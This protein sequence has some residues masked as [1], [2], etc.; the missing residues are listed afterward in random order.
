MKTKRL[1]SALL[2]LALVF[3]MIQPLISAFAYGESTDFVIEN[4]ILTKYTGTDSNVTVPDSVT[5]IGE[6]AFNGNTHIN[7]V[8]IPESVTEI[9]NVSFANCTNLS[10]VTFADKHNSSAALVIGEWVFDKCPITG[11]TFPTQLTQLKAGSLGSVSSLISISIKSA[12]ANIDANALSTIADG[13]RLPVLVPIG[14]S[15]EAS[16]RVATGYGNKFIARDITYG[17][18]DPDFV[19]DGNRKLVAYTGEGG[20]VIIPKDVTAIRN[21]N[22]V[23]NGRTDIKS[24]VIPAAVT[25]IEDCCFADCTNLSL[26]AFDDNTDSNANLTIKSFVF[27]NC[28]ITTLTLPTQLTSL[29]NNAFVN[30][31]SLKYITVKSVKTNL[32][33]ADALNNFA[34]SSYLPIRVDL[35]SDTYKNIKAANGYNNKFVCR[36]INIQVNDDYADYIVNDSRELIG[37]TGT[38]NDANVV[39]P[40]DVK[41]IVGSA[42]VFQGKT[43]IK[44]IT[45]N[46]GVTAILDGAFKDCSALS[47]LIIQDNNE[48]DANLSIGLNVF[49]GSNLTNVTLPLQYK[50]LDGNIFKDNNNIK[51]ITIKNNNISLATS[52]TLKLFTSANSYFPIRIDM[53]NGTVKN[54]I[55]N[56]DGYEEHYFV[57]RDINGGEATD[58][59]GDFVVDENGNFLEYKGNGGN[60]TIP[61]DVNVIPNGNNYFNG[62]T[63]LIS[64]YV[65]KNVTEIEDCAFQNCPKLSSVVFEDNNTENASL[66]MG[67]W[68]FAGDAITDITLPTHLTYIAN[69]AFG[70][71]SKLKYLVIKAKNLEFQ[72]ENAFTNFSEQS[73]FPIIV[74]FNNIGL[75]N[76]IKGLN[77]YASGSETDTNRFFCRDISKLTDNFGDFEVK[78]INGELTLIKYT[79]TSENVVIPGD[80]AVI[81]NSGD[82]FNGNQSIKSITIPGSVKIIENCAISNCNNLN[83]V[84]FEDN[85]DESAALSIGTWVFGGDPI[86]GIT[87]PTQLTYLGTGA[88]GGMD[89]LKY[90]V[91]KSRTLEFQDENA[92]SSFSDQSFFPI[93]VDLKN[94]ALCD[95]IKGLTDYATE[96]V[97]EESDG[98]KVLKPVNP[99]SHN[100]FMCRDINC[101]PSDDYGNFN[102][103]IID[104][105]LTLVEYKGTAENVVIPGDVEVLQD[106]VFFHSESARTHMKT[107]TVPYSVT[108]IQPSIVAGCLNLTKI[109]FT[110]APDPSKHSL[111]VDSFAF[112]GSG[113]EELWLPNHLTKLNAGCFGGIDNLKGVIITANNV[114]YDENAFQFRSYLPVFFPKTILQSNSFTGFLKT[115]GYGANA[116]FKL[117]NDNGEDKYSSIE[118]NPEFIVDG[119][120]VLL[121]Y[122]P[123]KDSNGNV[124]SPTEIV[125]PEDVRVLGNESCSNLSELKKLVI[126][127]TVEEIEPSALNLCE[128][129]VDI[130]FQNAPDPTQ[131][132]LTIDGFAFLNTAVEELWLPTHLTKLN[133]GCFGGTSNLKGVIITAENVE[134]DSNA[135]QFCS[136][137]TVFFPRENSS[138]ASF[139][140]LF[141]TYEYGKRAIFR[142]LDDNGNTDYTKADDDF[143]IDGEGTLTEYKGKGGIVCVPEGVVTLSEGVF[144]KAGYTDSS[145][146]FVSTA[147]DITEI[148]LP[149]TLRKIENVAF[150]GCKNLVHVNFAEG[151]EIINQW[152]FNDTGIK[153]LVLPASIKYLDAGSLCG[154]SDDADFILINSNDCKINSQA[155]EAYGWGRLMPVLVNRGSHTAEV[156]PTLGGYGKEGN[157]R[158]FMRYIDQGIPDKTYVVDYKD[159]LMKYCGN[160]GNIRIPSG[161]KRIA[162]QVFANM[163]SITSVTFPSSLKRIDNV[164]FAGCK[165]LANVTFSEGFE[166]LGEWVF[167]NTALTSII[168]PTTLKELSSGSCSGMENIK[169]IAILAQDVNINHSAFGGYEWDFNLPVIVPEGSKCA[170]ILPTLE[171]YGK[172]G[173][174]RFFM[175]YLSQGKPDAEFCVDYRGV[176]SKYNGVGGDVIIPYGVVEIADQVF[177]DNLTIK[178]VN[179]PTSVKKINNVVFANCTNLTKITFNEGLEDLGVWAFSNT[180]ITEMVLPS[181]LKVAQAGAISGMPSIQKVTFYSKNTSCDPGFCGMNG[182]APA[183]YV[184]AGSNTE[185]AASLANN[186]ND[187]NFVLHQIGEKVYANFT[188]SKGEVKKYTGFETDVI[189]PEGITKIG[190]S[191]FENNT[192]IKSVVLPGTLKSISAAAFKGCTSLEKITL[193]EGI[194]TIDEWAFDNTAISSITF[195]STLKEIGVGSF[196]DSKLLK[197]VYC[198]SYNLKYPLTMGFMGAFIGD[199]TIT[200]HGS[201]GST[202]Q[203]YVNRVNKPQFTFKCLQLTALG[204]NGLE[205]AGDYQIRFRT[206]SS[207]IDKIL[208]DGK[209]Y[210]IVSRGALIAPSD[211]IEASSEL[212]V[213]TANAVNAEQTSVANKSDGY[214]EYEML[215]T[216]IPSNQYTRSFLYRPYIV[217]KDANGKDAYFYGNTISR[218]VNAVKSYAEGNH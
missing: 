102:V 116:Y 154:L 215:L 196:G 53:S 58:D 216:D 151:C 126:P 6:A 3:S 129:L 153:Q 79:G 42:D 207:A 143:V 194:T 97:T 141:K 13:R 128:K 23:F 117:L 64:V 191:A 161:V 36:D 185:K 124:I 197:D 73:Y 33:S 80:I 165:N 208:I 125:I 5:I 111:T 175:R 123:K 62:R 94:T 137:L 74:D 132:S 82:I 44:S 9:R 119:N 8:Y 61:Y 100:K 29:S 2:S 57:C 218:T 136:Y 66:K 184:V 122:V 24:V 31:S 67:A 188:I 195:P 209:E 14:S 190:V 176:L 131:Y 60:V 47:S 169:Y 92:L 104:G 1:L 133:S 4:S 127:Y 86:K 156:I 108:N 22:D 211:S 39:I 162:E 187:S 118:K 25:Y 198:Y 201:M 213:S 7:S 152:V 32:E 99:D 142:F 56:A 38:Q 89:D 214:N 106:S 40:D 88:F 85:T 101:G 51:F 84:I 110:E 160:G 95:K 63:D 21:G 93:L 12:K 181:T 78:P 202:T 83:S 159:T 193:N 34:D 30:M 146:K 135:F 166:S 45:V 177:A 105:K 164:A 145:N 87:L 71:M 98:N 17:V 52:D 76:T 173:N 59:F 114:E 130:E 183:I 121:K 149:S 75:Y 140:N 20:N 199:E 134:Y 113:V 15:T 109:E 158:F 178:S 112:Q 27:S 168:F 150:S 157:N 206:Q 37:Y 179:I 182:K 41:T 28:P 189:I 138:S 212:T 55:Q 148:Y 48:K 91:I 49:D 70:G 180:G 204:A 192:Q 46:S 18:P 210:E 107:L 174:N 11:F 170:E 163:D 147:L 171:G 139:T 96:Y 115:K 81:P 72:D 19:V 203:E 120:G 26:I 65:H 186:D 167:Q 43:N 54:T 205:D 50:T 90:V 103:K 69:G 200:F 16:L 155:I 217:Y 68:L 172:E 144:A 77:G 35:G 10:S